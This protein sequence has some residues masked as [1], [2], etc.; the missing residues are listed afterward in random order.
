MN[1]D[2]IEQARLAITAGQRFA[3]ATIVDSTAKGTPQ[4]SGAKMI[5]FEDGSTFGTIG[6]GR[7]EKDAIAQCRQAIRTGRS[8]LKTYDFFGNKGQSVC[9]GQMKV[10]IEPVTRAR[11][12]ILCG[13]G[14][15]ALP[16]AF[17]VK[18]MGYH[19]TVIDSRRAYAN[20][21]RFPCADKILVG[22]YPTQIG[23]CRID[24]QTDVM[25]VTHGNEHDYE[26][27]RAVIDSPAGYIGCISSQAKR[28]KFLRRL[29]EDGVKP[30][31]IKRIS[32]P[33]GIDLGAQTPA[34]IAVSISAELV[35]RQHREDVDS[36]KFK[37][38]RKDR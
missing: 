24:G 32:I 4:K 36:D 16:L 30:A 18:S 23:K 1:E 17:M 27:L 3:F 38:K 34:E 20:K 22:K 13:G 29:R 26:C 9:G 6:G 12:F 11:K 35:Q 15:I 8:E 37:A 2:L 7:N 25:I 19:L 31:D 5:V 14:H 10:F 33:A 21:E 28:V